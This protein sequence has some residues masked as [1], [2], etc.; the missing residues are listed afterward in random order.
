[1]DTTLDLET[2]ERLL[3]AAMFRRHEVGGFSHLSFTGNSL[4]GKIV[5]MSISEMSLM[6]LS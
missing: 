1:V 6:A 5:I 4:R 3:L 2:A